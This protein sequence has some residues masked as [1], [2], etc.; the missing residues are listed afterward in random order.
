VLV[1]ISVRGGSLPK[2]AKSKKLFS[3]SSLVAQARNAGYWPFRLCFEDGLRRDPALRG[4]TRVRFVVE[5]SGRVKSERMAFT[6]LKDHT[7]A[8]C[9]S[10]RVRAFHFSPAPTKRVHADA[11]IDLGPGDAPLPEANVADAQGASS[12]DESGK[13]DG[14]AVG[15]A[16]GDQLSGHVAGCYERGLDRDPRLWG[17]LAILMDVDTEGRVRGAAEHESR[18]PDPM[19]FS[20]VV[21]GIQG[22][23]LPPP[24]GGPI[25]VVWP[26]KLGSPPLPEVGP[27]RSGSVQTP[28]ELK[29]TVAEAGPPRVPVA[30]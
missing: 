18:F 3:E 30:K 19:V 27:G 29:R 22:A 15:R 25:Q 7:V 13:F 4:K 2:R 20:C 23:A 24:V 16:L 21:E 14:A 11:T 17:R 12:S 28:V 10:A 8:K 9:L 26:L 5:T 1:D 6:E